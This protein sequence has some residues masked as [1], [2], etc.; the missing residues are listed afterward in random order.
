[1]VWFL[2]L[3]AVVGVTAVFVW[4]YRR[5]AARREQAS[6]ERFEQIF[7]RQAA[8][9]PRSAATAVP[10]APQQPAAGHEAVAR[11]LDRQHTLVYLLLKASL[12]SHAVFARVPLAS[13]VTATGGGPG[14]EGQRARRLAG[15]LLDFVVC[16]RD[17]RIVAVVMLETPAADAGGDGFVRNCLQD[18]GIRRVVMDP[19]ALPRGDALR[20]MI[21]GDA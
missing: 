1:L 13:V 12:P 4:D 3:L 11:F 17:M 8:P 18:A 20:S 5:K 6:R 15:Y 2:F 7:Q 9:A 19:A 14:E 10:A 16:D 21:C